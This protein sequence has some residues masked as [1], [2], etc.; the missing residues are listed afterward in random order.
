MTNPFKVHESFTI[1]HKILE[2]LY[3]NDEKYKGHHTQLGS[4]AISQTT[5]IP[6]DKIHFYH[7]LLKEVDEIK[8]CED[9]GQHLMT[10]TDQGDYAY[11]KGK[12]LKL[13]RDDMWDYF[14][15]PTRVLLPVFTF[16]LAVLAFYINY[17]S[18]KDLKESKRILQ[19]NITNTQQEQPA[20]KKGDN[21][22]FPY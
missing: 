12:Y 19:H 17:K 8:C 13:G 6:I 2:T 7:Q 16:G 21:I 10:L 20:A 22:P 1:R 3:K 11:V 5:S 9:K 18:Y 14:Y 15:Y 4:I